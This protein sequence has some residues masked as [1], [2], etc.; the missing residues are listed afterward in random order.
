[1]LA[2]LAGLGITVIVMGIG[3]VI[4]N[5][6]VLL[7]GDGKTLVVSPGYLAGKL[8]IFALGALAGGFTAARIAAGRSLFTVFLV[9]LV[10]LMSA[11]VPVLRGGAPEAGHPAWYPVAIAILTPLGVLVGGFMERRRHADA[12]RAP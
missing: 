9:A 2:L 6:A 5:L 12:G 11:I 1:M 3:T 10:L 7:A 8:I 4:A